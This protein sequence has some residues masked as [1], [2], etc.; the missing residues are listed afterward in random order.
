M[1]KP[2]KLLTN[3]HLLKEFNNN[4]SLAEAAIEVAYKDLAKEKGFSLKKVLEDVAHTR[5][6]EV[7]CDGKV[8]TDHT[9]GE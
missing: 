4:F 2:K 7:V 5:K 3:E 6:K 8:D 9:V 1:K